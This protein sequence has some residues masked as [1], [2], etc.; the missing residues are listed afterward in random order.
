MI[1]LEEAIPEGY[2]LA[3]KEEAENFKQ[4]WLEESKEQIGQ[5]KIAKLTNCYAVSN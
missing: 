1:K 3:S 5:W 4:F 2:H